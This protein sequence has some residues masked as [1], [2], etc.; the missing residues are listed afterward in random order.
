MPKL[1]SGSSIAPSEEVSLGYNHYKNYTVTF[2]AVNPPFILS[3]IVKS[4][5][6]IY[7][8]YEPR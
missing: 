6:C 7:I 1:A 3:W 2:L 4:S 5:V 8:F